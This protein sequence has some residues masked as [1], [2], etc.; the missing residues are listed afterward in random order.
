MSPPRNPVRFN[1]V[2]PKSLFTKPR[3]KKAGVPDAD[4]DDF[5]DMVNGLP[6]L[7]LL[8][9]S[10]NIEKSA[11]MPTVWIKDAFKNEANRTNYCKNHVLGDVPETL[12]DFKAFYEARRDALRARIVEMVAAKTAEGPAA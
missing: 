12:I 6:N 8:E 10:E 1:H 7:Q 4:I 11:S 3:L 9:G 5:Q 2:F